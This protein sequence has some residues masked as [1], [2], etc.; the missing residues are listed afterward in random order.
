LEIGVEVILGE[1]AEMKI[2]RTWRIG[3]FGS[4]IDDE[5]EKGLEKFWRG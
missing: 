4:L 2:S 3:D 1:N 5:F